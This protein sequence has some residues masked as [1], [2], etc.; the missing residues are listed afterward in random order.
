MKPTTKI[1]QKTE[2]LELIYCKEIEVI[3][4]C[5]LEGKESFYE[6]GS[7]NIPF[8]KVLNNDKKYTR[9]NLIQIADVFENHGWYVKILE[10]EG[11]FN[12]S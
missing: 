6:I 4:A 5:I 11:T 12:F 10:A 7:I 1:T 2:L 9:N 8:D 3:N